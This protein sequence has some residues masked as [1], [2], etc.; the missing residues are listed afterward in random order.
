MNIHTACL[1]T[2]SR[3]GALGGGGN[4]RSE[5]WH[6]RAGWEFKALIY[7]LFFLNKGLIYAHIKIPVRT[8]HE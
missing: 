4:L 6:L 7:A 3:Y 5:N 8:F 2:K 1:I